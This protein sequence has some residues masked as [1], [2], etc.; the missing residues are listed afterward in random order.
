MAWQVHQVGTQLSELLD[1]TL[2][3]GP[4]V[5]A[6][7]GEDMAVLVPIDEWKRLQQAK[8]TLKD[9]LTAPSPT[10][11]DMMIPERERA[12]YRKPPEF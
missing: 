8:P 2:N 4:Q 1:A 6:R 3:E 9:L 12:R 7:D 11:E 5:V 10:F